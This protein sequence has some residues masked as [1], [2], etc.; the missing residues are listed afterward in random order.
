M[1]PFPIATCFPNARKSSCSA[2]MCVVS[3]LASFLFLSFSLV[4]LC[5][6]FNLKSSAL[7]S[8]YT[9]TKRDSLLAGFTYPSSP[10]SMPR[11]LSWRS[12]SHGQPSST[13]APSDSLTPS[14]SDTYPS[15]PDVGPSILPAEAGNYASH[16]G[17]LNGKH[18]HTH[19]SPC[20]S[21]GSHSSKN[22]RRNL[23]T[24]DGIGRNA[25]SASCILLC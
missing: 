1:K 5:A 14:R 25:S 8:S 18:C 7:G 4:F 11:R 22:D 20:R 3:C 13:A 10:M 21:S 2:G 6:F 23:P 16:Q 24:P 15:A 9:M 17:V 19:S 12:R